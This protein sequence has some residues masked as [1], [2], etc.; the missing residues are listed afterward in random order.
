[1]FLPTASMSAFRSGQAA[2]RLGDGR[3]LIVGGSW[4]PGDDWTRA[5]IYE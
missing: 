4:W 1:V 3:V 5:E 2:V